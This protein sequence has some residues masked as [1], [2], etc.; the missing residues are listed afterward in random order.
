MAGAS[1]QPIS[2][3][4]D[5]EHFLSD[6]HALMA[7]GLAETP[8]R[9]LADESKG[10]LAN[11]KM[12]RSRLAYRV[13]IASGTPYK[14]I[15]HTATATEMI[16]SASLLHDDVIDGGFLRRGVPAF[17]VEKGIS[18]AILLGDMLL[19]KA[20]DIICQV[21]NSRLAH[22]LVL[23][24]GE[25]CQAESEQELIYRGQQTEWEN[26]VRIARCKTG[27]LFA[28][29][30]FAAAGTEP[31]AQAALKEAGYLVGTAYQLSD[32]ILDAKGTA[33]EAGKTLGT[34]SARAKNTAM[35]FLPEGVEPVA[36]I[37]SLCDQARALLDALPAAQAGW[38][39]YMKL[40]FMPGLRKHL[41]L[42]HA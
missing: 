7:H 40:D 38:D 4:D 31:A 24:T 39:A 12:L 1:Q 9:F 3:L 33:A 25:V 20:L 15:L 28:F 2:E 29:A 11:G 14:T 30:A 27:A 6:V 32:D 42:M 41:D 13:G 19:F 18:G 16:H 35:T 34:D 36:Y 5:V 22:P 21:E 8:L 17:W 10:L 37:E 26:C 23:F